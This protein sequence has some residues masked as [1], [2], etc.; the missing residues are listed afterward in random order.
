MK[1]LLAI[2]GCGIAA[3][4]IVCA[5][6]A[7]FPDISIKE[8][9]KA[10]DDKKVVVIDVNGSESYAKGHLPTALDYAAQKAELGKLLPEKK[11][12]LIVAYCGGPTCSAYQ[13]AA[14]AAKELGYTNVKH[15][16]AGISGWLQAEMPTEKGAAKVEEK[17]KS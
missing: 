10:I 13:Q 11:D 3:A 8:L 14:K 15:L 1:K 4:G 9:K 6:E 16:S 2:L 17:K 5:A 12:T 7:E